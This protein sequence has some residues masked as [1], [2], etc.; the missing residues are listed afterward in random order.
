MMIVVRDAIEDDAAQLLE[1]RRRLSV[2]TTF[3]LRESAEL[4]VAAD[5]QQQ[6]IHRLANQRNSRLLLAEADGALAGFLAAFGGEPNRLKHSALL[7]LGVL[8]EHWSQGIASQML[9]EIIAWAPTAGIK[10]LELTVHTTNLR[11]LSLYLKCGFQVEGT[12]RASLLV[13]G[14]YVDEYLMSL[15]TEV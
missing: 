4:P 10:R 2:E 8:R 1:L 9:G 5:E 12:R 3:M 13:D 7:A 11:A 15:I 6:L 14:Q